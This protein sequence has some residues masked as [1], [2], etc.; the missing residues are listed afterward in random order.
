VVDVVSGFSRRRA[1]LGRGQAGVFRELTG[2]IQD[3][4][5]PPWGLHCD[6]GSEFINDYLLLFC[7]KNKLSFTRSRPYKK[8]DNAH[9]EQKNLQY[10]REIVGYERYDTPEAVDWLN[11]VYACLDPYANLFLPM[12]KVITKERCGSHIRKKFDTAR[13]PFER[14]SETG[15]MT[16]KARLVLQYQRKTLNPLAIHHQIEDLLSKGP[17]LVPLEAQTTLNQEVVQG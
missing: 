17:S 2:I 12:R 11:Q 6:N 1:V 9:V 3:W 13:T 4:P 14:L 5:T 16:L 15:A 8:N 10:V 7:Q